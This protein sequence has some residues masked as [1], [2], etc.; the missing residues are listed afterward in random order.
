MSLIAKKNLLIQL[1]HDFKLPE[2][3]LFPC[4]PT[5]YRLR[6][7]FSIFHRDDRLDY[8][9]WDSQRR[10]V[11]IT[12]FPRTVPD[13]QGLMG[14][15]RDYLNG[16]ALLK[17]RLFQVEFLGTTS[18]DLLLTLIYHRPLDD[19]W[20]AA[21]ERL[22]NFFNINVI[23][24][25]RGQKIVLGR[26]YVEECL[27]VRGR[28]FLYR[29]Y[30]NSFSQPN[31]LICQAMLHWAT[32][33]LAGGDLLE[34]Y[35]GHGNFTLPL[36]LNFDR[37]LATEI[38]K[39]SVQALRENLTLNHINNVQVARLSAEEFCQA[40]AGQRVFRRLLTESISLAD[41][42]FSAVLVDPPRAGL[43]AATLALIGEFPRIL[44][45]SCNPHSLAANLQQLA[46]S[47]H[48]AALAL[49]DQFPDTAHLESGVLLQRK[50]H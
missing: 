6:A 34:L 29:Q 33:Q 14:P 41:Y 43:D 49:F 21:A 39:S 13:I 47:H 27:P 35:C 20:R 8:A 28:R 18:R 17:E 12:E 46:A 19:S 24:R 11:I 2:I 50:A 45:I 37:V 4:P 30:E 10:P 36:S 3:E 22:Q 38:S 23:G 42:D 16:D 15:L 26:D 40:R 7:E 9:M 5:G 31:G 1:L 32:A 44:Y 25:S 48:I